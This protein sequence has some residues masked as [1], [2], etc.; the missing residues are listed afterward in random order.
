MTVWYIGRRWRRF[1]S[2]SAFLT[3]PSAVGC[4]CLLWQAGGGCTIHRHMSDFPLVQTGLVAL[5]SVGIDIRRGALD[6]SKTGILKSLSRRTFQAVA[7]VQA[8]QMA[9]SWILSFIRTRSDTTIAR[10]EW[11]LAAT[12]GLASTALGAAMIVRCGGR[13]LLGA[14]FMITPSLYIAVALRETLVLER[15]TKHLHYEA[16]GAIAGAL[17]LLLLPPSLRCLLA[18]PMLLPPVCQACVGE[19][20]LG[21][22]DLHERGAQHDVVQAAQG[23]YS[24]VALRRIDRSAYAP[25]AWL[26]HGSQTDEKEVMQAPPAQLVAAA[27]RPTSENDTCCAFSSSLASLA[28]SPPTA[29]D[30]SVAG[31]GDV[32][33]EGCENRTDSDDEAQPSVADAN[34]SVTPATAVANIRARYKH[35]RWRALCAVTDAMQSARARSQ[36]AALRSAEQVC[37][38]A[39]LTGWLPADGTCGSCRSANE[40]GSSTT[41]DGDVLLWIETVESSQSCQSPEIGGQA[42]ELT[43]E[44]QTRQHHEADH[45]RLMLTE[46]ARLTGTERTACSLHCCLSAPPCAHASSA[47]WVM[48]LWCSARQII[49]ELRNGCLTSDVEGESGGGAK[50]RHAGAVFEPF[51]GLSGS[52]SRAFSSPSEEPAPGY[53]AAFS[54]SV[55]LS[56]ISLPSQLYS[57]LIGP[58]SLFS[59]LRPDHIPLYHDKSNGAALDETVEAAVIAPLTGMAPLAKLEA[60]RR[61]EGICA[62]LV[63]LLESRSAPAPALVAFLRAAETSEADEASRYSLTA[64]LPSILPPID[65][66][67]DDDIVE[68]LEPIFGLTPDGSPMWQSHFAWFRWFASG[69]VAVLTFLLLIRELH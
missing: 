61:I 4:G 14:G 19:A 63:P 44:G 45:G 52:T 3:D 66:T 34:N 30:D 48:P 21:K 18:V 20:A 37:M 55:S 36:S 33:I 17:P 67:I 42:Q 65:S 26:E 56:S 46:Q 32:D 8:S 7:A 2:S 11:A 6:V 1:L 25:L 29:S 59:W 23:L 49:C 24:G 69:D 51:S 35:I 39:K 64:W 15:N 38:L 22:A 40:A 9:G 53:F 10:C 16:G 31:D 68:G 60:L 57:C 43:I 58:A 13:P 27:P 12:S 47:S 50:F 41:N 62:A 5:A 28:Y 54:P